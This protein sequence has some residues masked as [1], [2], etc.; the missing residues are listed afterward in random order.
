[1]KLNGEKAR[2][3]S[4]HQSQLLFSSADEAERLFNRIMFIFYVRKNACETARYN[5]KP[6][7]SFAF[8]GIEKA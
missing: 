1:M 4:S 5:G 8:A 6:D 3:N 7:F 2:A